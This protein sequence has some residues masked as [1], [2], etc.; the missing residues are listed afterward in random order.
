MART[1]VAAVRR[2]AVVASASGNGKTTVGALLAERLGVPFVE[3]DALV[4]GPGWAEIPDEALRSTLAPVL[5]GEG[6]V[7]D[8]GYER[9]LGNMVVEAADLVV[10]L[11]LPVR[12]WLPRLVRRT[13]TRAWRREELWNG[14][15]ESLRAAVWGRNSLFGYALRRHFH[16]RREWPARFASMPVRRLRSP[17]DV[18]ALLAEFGVQ[19][20]PPSLR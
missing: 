15:R 16:C 12:V 5:A 17:A 7:V 13:S 6:W 20:V 14:N 3:L 10:W 18:D 11:D 19:Y 9:K 1:R 4:H 8:G 2:I